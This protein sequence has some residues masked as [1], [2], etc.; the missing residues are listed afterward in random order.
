MKYETEIDIASAKERFMGN[1][2]LYKKFLFQ[3]PEQTLFSEFE[4]Q[5]EEGNMEEAFKTAH[6][7]KSMVGN[8]SLNTFFKRL[9]DDVE[10]LRSGES[11]S[12]V[13]MEELHAAYERVLE[14][15][16][17]IQDEDISLF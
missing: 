15:V 8:L 1:E 12:Q 6:T 14:A 9:Y 16:K 4:R 17:E 13:E 3:L 11:L 2:A 7:M 10:V 5:I